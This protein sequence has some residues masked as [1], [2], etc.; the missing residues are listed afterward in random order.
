MVYQGSS[1]AFSVSRVPDQKQ[2]A[3]SWI[4]D[5]E[6]SEMQTMLRQAREDAVAS[7]EAAEAYR[8]AIST[9]LDEADAVVTPSYA[10][11]RAALKTYK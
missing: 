1:P 3:M 8:T 5:D 2:Q 7:K 9:F 11:L 4:G 6:Y 10:S